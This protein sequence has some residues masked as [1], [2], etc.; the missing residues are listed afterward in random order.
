VR[1][2]LPPVTWVR[3]GGREGRAG[4]HGASGIFV[5][6]YTSF[7]LTLYISARLALRSA[8]TDDVHLSARPRSAP[9]N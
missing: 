8:P 1:G 7:L 3:I 5:L 9:A 6:S 2:R 4:R